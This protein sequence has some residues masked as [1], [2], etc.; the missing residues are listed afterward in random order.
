MEGAIREAVLRLKYREL[1]AIAPTLARLLAEHL[2][3]HSV[4]ADL[5][6]PVPLHPRREAQ[7]G[8]NQS[9][10][11][12]RQV[13]RLLGLPVEERGL[14][15]VKDSPPQARTLSRRER[16]ANV[17]GAFE[18]R[19]PFAGRHVLLVDDVCTTGATLEACA[20]ALRGAGAVSVWGL[21]VAREL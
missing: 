5:L 21:A 10:L 9:L 2:G 14:A 16:W 18:A 11:L 15:R 1:R 20:Q 19:V 6:V 17:Q 3:S 4:E 13:G 8:F 12:A 7:R